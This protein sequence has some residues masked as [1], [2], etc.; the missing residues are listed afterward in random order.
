MKNVS[1]LFA[2]FSCV[3]LGLTG[4]EAPSG[5]SSAGREPPVSASAEPSLPSIADVSSV[6]PVSSAAPSAAAVSSTGSAY[7][8][9]ERL[10]GDDVL[11]RPP[12]L[13]ITCGDIEFTAQK[14]G[15]NWYFDLPDGKEYSILAKGIH[16]LSRKGQLQPLETS[17]DK[18]IVQ[19]E[20][21]PD[22]MT[23]WC[24]DD[25]C[26]EEDVSAERE[27]AVVSGNEIVLKQGGYIYEIM[28]HWTSQPGYRGW[29]YYCF[30]IKRQ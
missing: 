29:S 26:W 5:V 1:V 8:N 4:C 2:A 28:A 20:V 11:T 15:F 22:S 18:A 7:V 10:V 30:Y 3:L 25:A 27:D 14:G 16:P 23:A 6:T 13:K 24:W 12:S 17:A 21:M 19:C 9:P